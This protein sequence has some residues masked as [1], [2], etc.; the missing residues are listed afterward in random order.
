MPAIESL[1]DANLRSPTYYLA[2]TYARCRYCGLSTHLMA[3]AVPRTHETLDDDE[4]ADDAESHQPAA[5][6]WRRLDVDAFL[7]YVERLSH[8]V[9]RRLQKMAP[10]FRPARS[11]TTQSVYWVNHCEHC[12]SLLEDHELHCEPEGAFMPA[13]EAE[14]AQIHLLQV[15][16]PIE[17]VAAGYSPDPAF[18]GLMRTA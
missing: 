10:C 11:A 2:R 15:P 9:R 4:P 17:V 14:A 16:E 1:P 6:A 12:D 5:S 8:D 7:F 13:S 18:F 3:L